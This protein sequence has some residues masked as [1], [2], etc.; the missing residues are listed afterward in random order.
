MKC[1]IFWQLDIPLWMQSREAGWRGLC[2]LWGSPAFKAKSIKA[3][4]CRGSAVYHNY[5]GDGHARLAKRI[6]SLMYISLPQSYV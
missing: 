6:V 5:G 4:N 1:V 3:R 2:R